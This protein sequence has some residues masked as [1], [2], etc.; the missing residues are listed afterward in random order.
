MIGCVEMQLGTLELEQF[1]P[2]V[3]CEGW[4]TI[5]ENRVG[6]SMDIEDIIHQNLSHDGGCEWVLE[7]KKMS[8]F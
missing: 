7:G 1:L 5:R 4:I 6:H 2:K 3:S 8:I